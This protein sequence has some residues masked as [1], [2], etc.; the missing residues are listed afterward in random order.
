MSTSIQRVD[1][2]QHS[3]HNVRDA[4]ER[5]KGTGHRLHWG[6]TERS[7]LP[8]TPGSFRKCSS[9]MGQP[10]AEGKTFKKVT[11]S[12]RGRSFSPHKAEWQKLTKCQT[13]SRCIQMSRCSGDRCNRHAARLATQR[14]HAGKQKQEPLHSMHIYVINPWMRLHLFRPHGKC[15]RDANNPFNSLVCVW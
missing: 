6:G 14:E 13:L 8:L 5:L 9:D 4:N 7:Q 2:N 15:E 12:E 3:W 1:F 10:D 11:G